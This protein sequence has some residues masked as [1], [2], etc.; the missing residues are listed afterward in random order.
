M[1]DD[2]NPEWTRED[3][4]R[5]TPV[6]GNLAAALSAIRKARGA[7]KAPTKKQVSLRLDQDVLDRFKATGPGWQRRMNE[8]LRKAQL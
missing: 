4:A 5:A 7:Q 6:N 3:F 1:F 8:V 2:D